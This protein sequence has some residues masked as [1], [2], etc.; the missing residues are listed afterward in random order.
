[1]Y[2]EGALLT[3]T[4]LKSMLGTARSLMQYILK[5]IEKERLERQKMLLTPKRV[6]AADLISGI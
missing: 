6:L 4:V 3:V 5:Q 2:W 1:M